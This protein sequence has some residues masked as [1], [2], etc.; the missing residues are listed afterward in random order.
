MDSHDHILAA[1]IIVAAAVATL[2]MYSFTLWI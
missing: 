2:V 1:M